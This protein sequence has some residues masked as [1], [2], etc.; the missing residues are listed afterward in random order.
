MTLEEMRQAHIAH[1]HH[2]QAKRIAKDLEARF[3]A[4][5]ISGPEDWESGQYVCVFVTLIENVL[6]M[7]IQLTYSDKD[8]HYC[9][10]KPAS[11]SKED[12]ELFTELMRTRFSEVEPLADYARIPGWP[13]EGTSNSDFETIA[14]Q[15]LVAL[16][17]VAKVP[18]PRW[19]A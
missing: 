12:I 19:D 18:A 16:A 5:E 9:Q 3:P 17:F 2:E 7:M 15:V 1:G 4:L 8:R 14:K 13:R 10:L 6:R 11:T